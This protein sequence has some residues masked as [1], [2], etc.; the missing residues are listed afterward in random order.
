MKGELRVPSP[1]FLAGWWPLCKSATICSL[2]LYIKDSW[3]GGHF[4]AKRSLLHP[5]SKKKACLT[6]IDL[7]D[8]EESEAALLPG[9]LGSPL[10]DQEQLHSF[11]FPP[12][13]T[14]P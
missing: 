14:F 13:Q 3:G 2:A 8:S 11:K 1:L 9:S 12:E 10:R 6:F 4:Q 5:F 7:G